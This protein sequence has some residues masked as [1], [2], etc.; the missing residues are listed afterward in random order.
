MKKMLATMLSGVS[1][2]STIAVTDSCQEQ[3]A[4][5]KERSKSW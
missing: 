2:S 4:D 5:I 1:V 3:R